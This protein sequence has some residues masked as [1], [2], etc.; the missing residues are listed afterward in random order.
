MSASSLEGVVN[1]W[2]KTFM[3]TIKLSNALIKEVYQ[4][5]T[6]M[7]QIG[8]EMFDLKHHH[9]LWSTL[10]FTVWQKLCSCHATICT[11]Y[12][13]NQ[14]Q[15]G[16]TADTGTVWDA[17][18]IK[19]LKVHFWCGLHWHFICPCFRSKFCCCNK[20]HGEQSKDRAIE[21]WYAKDF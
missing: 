16:S 12:D 8:F 18:S 13:D 3:L 4:C 17:I 21:A 6:W 1:K 14:Q 9:Y 11:H 20:E 10:K 7:C 15:P 5:C 2:F 19:N